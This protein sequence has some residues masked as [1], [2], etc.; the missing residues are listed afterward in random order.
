MAGLYFT[1]T[2]K[3][4]QLV[5]IQAYCPIVTVQTHVRDFETCLSREMG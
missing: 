4:L 1:D 3:E 2:C 5:D